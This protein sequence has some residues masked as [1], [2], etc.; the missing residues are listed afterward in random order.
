MHIITNKHIIM[1]KK[2]DSITAYLEANNMSREDMNDL[3][4]R[5]AIYLATDCA[6]NFDK[7]PGI[8]EQVAQPLY[9]FREILQMVE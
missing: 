3:I 7:S 2:Y 4:A 9:F 8:T 6:R 1:N 5:A